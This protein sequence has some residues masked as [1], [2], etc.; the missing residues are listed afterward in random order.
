MGIAEKVNP[1]FA[2]FNKPWLFALFVAPLTFGGVTGIFV[3]LLNDCT[4]TCIYD[5]KTESIVANW[6][7]IGELYDQIKNPPIM[8]AANRLNRPPRTTVTYE[9][10]FCVS[11]GREQRT[12]IEGGP[13]DGE[14]LDFVCALPSPDQF[15]SWPGEVTWCDDENW[16]GESG[17]Y[18]RD[19]DAGTEFAA[20]PCGNAWNGASEFDYNGV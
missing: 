6:P 11:Y 2:Y 8:S 10:T 14:I 16:E 20:N 9:S 19:K 17:L 7:Q 18:K 12:T 3:S 4:T 13:Y 1:G 5:G 15:E